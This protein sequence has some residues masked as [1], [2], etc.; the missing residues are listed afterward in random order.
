MAARKT[1]Q[2]TLSAMTISLAVLVPW[3]L[4][5]VPNSGTLFLPMHFPILLGAFFLEPGFALMAGVL[6]PILSTLITGMPPAFPVLP[7]M[8]AELG[9]YALSASLLYRSLKLDKS[10]ALVGAMLLG[11]AAAS[12]AAWVLV[13]AFG[14]KLPAP[15]GF[16][17]A[18]ITGSLPG[19][20]IQLAAIPALVTIVQKG[21][22]AR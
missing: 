19:I 1:N 2:L 10:I 5:S 14:A 17:V 12:I 21:R 22:T 8:A 13:V 15:W 11:R 18:T 6:S 16:F 9:T 4:H 20:A 3:L 7:F